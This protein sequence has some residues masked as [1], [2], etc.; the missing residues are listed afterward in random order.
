MKWLI[1]PMVFLISLAVCAQQSALSG[2]KW[3]YV[4]LYD[5]SGRTLWPRGTEQQANLATQFLKDVVHPGSDMGSL[6]GFADQTSIDVKNSTNPSE[7]AAM[8]VH[9]GRGG[10]AVYD[11]VVAAARWLDKQDSSD[12][13]KIM[14]VF[15]D[16]EDY[17]SYMNLQDTI[18]AVQ[19]THV[20]VVFL[21]LQML[22]TRFKGKKSSSSSRARTGMRTLYPRRAPL[23][24]PLSST[25]WDDSRTR[26]K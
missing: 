1:A 18:S 14:F 13:Q 26:T 20:P 15:S 19:A 16:F 3:D 8:L 21:R 22:S 17:A 5:G 10:T 9:H 24:S 25:I 2:T 7:L 11:A 6:I 4:V 23:I 12:G